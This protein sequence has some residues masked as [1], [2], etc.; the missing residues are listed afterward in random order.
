MCAFIFIDYSSTRK[1]APLG[2]ECDVL[3][4]DNEKYVQRKKHVRVKMWYKVL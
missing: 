2:R 3:E 1:Y 4:T